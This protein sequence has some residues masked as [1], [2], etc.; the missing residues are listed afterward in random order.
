VIRRV[1]FVALLV[2]LAVALAVGARAHAGVVSNAQRAAALEAQLRCP[3]CQDATVAQSSASSAVAI[4][5]QVTAMVAAGDSDAQIESS[6]ESRYGPSILLL[7]PTRGLASL[8]W[9]VPVVLGVGAV[10][11]VGSLFWRRNRE[12]ERLRQQPEAADPIEVP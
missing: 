3:S 6:L 10:A 2:V 4:R 7:P 11:V 1:S 9:V 5:H 8:V 12:F